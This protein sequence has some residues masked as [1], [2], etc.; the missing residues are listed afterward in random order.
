MRVRS[1]GLQK[2]YL[3]FQM[4]PFYLTS[5][6]SGMVL[7]IKEPEIENKA[8][9][10]NETAP[11]DGVRPPVPVPVGAKASMQA[12]EGLAKPAVAAQP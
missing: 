9:I 2:T 1:R 5:M 8:E 6:C 4:T 7:G 11:E 3:G 10:D 12:K